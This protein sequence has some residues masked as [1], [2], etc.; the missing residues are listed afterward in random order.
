MRGAAVVGMR[1]VAK[2]AGVSLGTVSR[3]INNGDHVSADVRARVG[4]AMNE[5]KYV[6]NELARNLSKNRTNTVGVIVPT[7]RHPFFA[8][9]VASL[10]TS[11]EAQGFLTLPCSTIDM[12]QGEEEYVD[13]L[14]RHMLDGIIMGAHTSHSADYWT[15]IKRPIVSFDRYLGEGIP[16]VGSNHGQGARLTADLLIKTG[17]RHA[18][19]LSGPLSQF[20]D[21]KRNVFGFGGDVGMNTSYVSLQY[22]AEIRSALER[23]GVRWDYME[24]G[25]IDDFEAHERAVHNVFERYPDVDAIIASDEVA[26]LCV[27]EADRR[28]IDIPSEMQVIAYDGSYVT[29]IA[30]MRMTSICQDF[31]S[32]SEQLARSLISLIEGDGSV[33]RRRPEI[34]EIDMHLAPRETTR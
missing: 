17:A 8:T 12:H 22:Y 2:K 14:R 5:L 28:G 9:L 13:M 24:A 32:I 16:V 31:T 15:N 3:V 27:Q 1:E 26:A 4:W 33:P 21:L 6:P 30:G 20:H 11:F 19:N 23:S 29:Q 18:V 34:Q 7:I 10:Q 25:E